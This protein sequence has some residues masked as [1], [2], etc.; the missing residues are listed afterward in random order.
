MP[1]AGSSASGRRV[2]AGARVATAASPAAA[3]PTARGGGTSVARGLRSSTPPQTQ[4]FQ[5]LAPFRALRQELSACQPALQQVVRPA[6]ADRQQHADQ[7]SQAQRPVIQRS[8]G[9]GLGRLLGDRFKLVEGFLDGLQLLAVA[10]TEIATAG[11]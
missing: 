9:T 11:D 10:G 1:S 6:F 4:A 3:G 5:A 2:S 7:Q 8:G